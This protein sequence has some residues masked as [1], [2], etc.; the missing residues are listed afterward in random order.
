MKNHIIDLTTQLL[1]SAIDRNTK[2]GK[3]V[4]QQ[5]LL[6]LN[7]EI[8]ESN[9][10][11]ILKDLNSAYIGIEAHGYLTENEFS[12]LKKLRELEAKYT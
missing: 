1:R 7:T 10:L 11:E 8:S 4:C 9:V 2:Q 6:K 5:T 12:I 3:L